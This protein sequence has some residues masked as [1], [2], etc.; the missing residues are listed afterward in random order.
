[1]LDDW[2]LRDAVDQLPGEIFVFPASIHQFC[3]LHRVK[4]L[5][6]SSLTSSEASGPLS[7]SFP[8]LFFPFCAAALVVGMEIRLLCGV[9]FGAMVKK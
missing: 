7:F 4:K 8:L 1:M 9:A 5:Q 6:Y 3:G 2:V